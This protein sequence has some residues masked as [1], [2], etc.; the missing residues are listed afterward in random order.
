MNWVSSGVNHFRPQHGQHF[1]YFL[2]IHPGLRVLAPKQKIQK[3]VV[4][5]IHQNIQPLGMANRQAR[6]MPGEKFRNKQVVFQ[7][8]PAAAP[9][10]FAQR[11]RIKLFGKVASVL[12]LLPGCGVLHGHAVLFTPSGEPSVL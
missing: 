7:Q 2:C 5:Q 4:C 9:F 1:A 6:F 11:T 12:A 8:A 3:V 10:E